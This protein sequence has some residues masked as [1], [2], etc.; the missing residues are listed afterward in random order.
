MCIRDRYITQY[1][2]GLYFTY[3]RDKR[4][5]YTFIILDYSSSNRRKMSNIVMKKEN[6]MYWVKKD[7]GPMWTRHTN[8]IV[9]LKC[10]G[11]VA[12][13]FVLFL[14]RCKHKI[15]SLLLRPLLQLISPSCCRPSQTSSTFRHIFCIYL[16]H[17]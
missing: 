5:L 4:L 16:L 2:S 9:P 17:S 14:L 13:A 11:R 3:N 10:M 8:Q 12:Y 15:Q 7:R 6:V 1:G